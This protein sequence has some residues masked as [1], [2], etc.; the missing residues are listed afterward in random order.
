VH[1][2]YG[3][4][5]EACLCCAFKTMAQTKSSIQSSVQRQS[6]VTTTHQDLPRRPISIVIKGLGQEWNK[7]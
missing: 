4:E 1:L 7:Q 3:F 2:N 6:K 5:A